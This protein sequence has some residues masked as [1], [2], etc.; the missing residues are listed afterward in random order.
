MIPLSFNFESS[1]SGWVGA[2]AGVDNDVEEDC[3][4]IGEDGR[5]DKD[6]AVGQPDQSYDLPSGMHD[7]VL[8]VFTLNFDVVE[9]FL[10]M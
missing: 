8:R 1:H 6:E 3:R 9:T 10:S 7:P 4:K 2:T 5:W